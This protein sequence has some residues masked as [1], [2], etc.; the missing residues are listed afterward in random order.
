[1][2]TDRKELFRVRFEQH[3]PRLCSIAYGYVSD[4]D[5]SE[6]IV[7][8]L[9][10][11]IWD[12]GKDCLPEQ[13]LTAYLTTAVKNRCIS[14]LR[15]KK[16]DT[17]SIE[18]YPLAD[19]H[20]AH[21][22]IS[23]EQQQELEAWIAANSA[24]YRRLR[25]LTDALHPHADESN[26]DARRAWMKIA[27][28]LKDKTTE[29]HR[30]RRFITFCSIAASLLLL[31]GTATVYLFRQPAVRYENNGQTARSLLLPDSSEVILYPQTK[32]SFRYAPHHSERLAK[33]EG[34]AFFHVKRTDGKPFRVTTEEVEVEVL[35]TSFLVDATQTERTGVFV[36]S[37]RVKVSAED[38]DL[39]LHAHEKAELS[40]G[41]LQKGTIDDPATFFNRKKTKMVFNQT[42]LKDIIKEV[43]KQTGIRIEL[44]RGVEENTVTTRIDPDNAE[45]IAAELAFL[46]GCKCDTLKRGKLYRL[47]YD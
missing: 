12:K 38:H 9:F 33:L 46:C 11:H 1:M 15:R 27:P 6:D 45:G 34:K 26:F 24:E 18:D 7:Q 3:Y 44:G 21:E 13:E 31:L 4:Y 25:R 14:F 41:N 30:T 10:I 37:G 42:P 23:A 8:E 29:T 5:E 28:K 47:R 16:E 2:R 43:E 35:G 32:L 39:V 40:D 20:L 19:H 22:H 17:V 36:E